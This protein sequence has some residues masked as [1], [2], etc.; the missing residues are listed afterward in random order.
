MSFDL[1]KKFK[2][3]LKQDKKEVLRAANNQVMDYSGRALLKAKV[4]GGRSHYIDVIVS[5]DLTNEVLLS[6]HDLVNLG[7]I[8]DF[9]PHIRS[10]QAEEANTPIMTDDSLAKILD[11]FADTVSDELSEHRH[12]KGPAMKIHLRGYTH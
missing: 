4:S 9:F 12:M 10:L 6:W 5:K 2:I 1:A 8:P 3:P 11:D 7:V